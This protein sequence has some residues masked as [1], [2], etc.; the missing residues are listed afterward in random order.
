[1]E[2]SGLRKRVADMMDGSKY[3]P[4]GYGMASAGQRLPCALLLLLVLAA[5]AL[6]VVV[7]H[8]VREQRAFAVVLKERDVQA[9]SLRILLQK[10]KAYGKET[11]R[12]AEEMKATMSS[13]RTQKTDLKTK[14]KALEATTTILKNTQKELE[15]SLKERE[16]RI[17]QMEGKAANL[18][19]TRKA[20][21]TSLKERENRIKQMQDKVTSLEKTMKEQELSLKA[22]DSRIRQLE[23][24]A[25][26]EPHPDQMAALMEILQRKEAELEEIKTRFQD[27]RTTDRKVVSR[28]STLARTNPTTPAVVVAEKVTNSSRNST[29]RAGSEEKRA[30]NTTVTES[31]LQKPKTRSLEEKQVKLAVTGNTQVDDLQEQDTDFLDMDDIYGDS[32]AKKSEL[33]RRNKKVLTDSDVENQ[34]SGHPL[35]QQDGHHIRYNKLLEKENIKTDETKKKSNTVG[36]LEKISKDS[37]SDVNL[38]GAVQGMA[39]AAGVK[40][41]VPVNDDLQQNKKPKNKKSKSK[42]KMMM[43]TATVNGDGEVAKGR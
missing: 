12:K 13:L 7:M 23:E 34:K 19:S 22:R 5:G 37:L 40:P 35:D 41:K 20:L 29:I 4:K 27:N 36:H 30:G 1:M 8:K 9:V 39:G 6:S 17:S 32:H 43:D 15:A 25:T 14:L 18:H 31:K 42:K 2:S 33:A 24:K 16:S 11:K 10:E 26:A 28:K 3:K 21:E 38:E